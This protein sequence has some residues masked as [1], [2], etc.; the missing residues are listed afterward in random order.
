VF[1]EIRRLGPWH[2]DIQLTPEFSTG[3]AYGST[4]LERE[5]NQGVSLISP[6]ESFSKYV[7]QIFGG[8]LAGKTF[9]D[10]ACNAGAYCFLAREFAADYCFG[11]DVR[12][13]W[14]D[15]ARFVQSHRTV[16]PVDHIEIR[17]MDLLDLHRA[18]LKP[19]DFVLFKG[20]FYHL[21][22]PV[23]SLKTVA[24]LTKEVLWFNSAT[25]D[26]E[27]GN[28]LYCTFENPDPVM[29]GVHVLSWMPTGSAVIAKILHWAGFRDIRLTMYKRHTAVN[30]PRRGRIEVF[31]ART[32]G[33]LEGLKNATPLYPERALGNEKKRN[34]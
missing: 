32:P 13:H 14:I 8:S 22:D 29:S 16:A 33:F 15:Q 19:F 24:D 11:F 23:N 7:A 9:L 27:D 10:C 20:I 4:T 2:M 34:A 28:S 17:Q 5:Q 21:P 1:E 31:A 6:R 12:Q 25:Y 26:D 3:S 30:D 18:G